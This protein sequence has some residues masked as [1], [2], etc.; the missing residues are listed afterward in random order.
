MRNHYDTHISEIIPGLYLG[1]MWATEPQCL[2]A[3][4]I[5]CV[6]NVAGDITDANKGRYPLY[7]RL[8]LQIDDNIHEAQRMCDEIFPQAFSFID[9]HFPNRRVLVHCVAGVSRSAAVVTAWLMH[10][11]NISM[12]TAYEL[13]KT[14][15]PNVSPNKGFMEMLKAY[16]NRN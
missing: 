11:N 9:S 14:H 15:R 13:V 4:N 7:D 5:E 10:K 8:V 3:Y 2:K 6:L 16:D 12:E 1:G